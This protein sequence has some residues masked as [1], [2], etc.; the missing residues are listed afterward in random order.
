MNQDLLAQLVKITPEEQSILNGGAVNLG[1]YGAGKGFTVDSARLLAQGQL[2]TLRP[3]TRFAPFPR[4]SH[5]YVEMMYMCAGQTIHVINGEAPVT[6]NQGELLLLNQHASHAIQKAGASD[7]AVNFIVL[8]QFFDEALQMLGTENV[9]GHFLLGALQSSRSEIGYLHFKA[10][11]TL[12]VQA[13]VESM[14]WSL[15][16]G[17]NNARKI[18]QISMGL[19][20]LHLLNCTQTLSAEGAVHSVSPMVLAAL[21]E[22]EENCRG[23]VLKDV[24][25]K[26]DVSLSYLSSRIKADT[27]N[28]F[29]VLLQQKRLDKAT[30][31]LRDTMLSVQEIISAVGYENTSYFYRIFRA[32][33]GVSPK[34]YRG[35]VHGKTK[36]NP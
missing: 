3:H 19:L 15:L 13:L 8:P 1:S 24:A 25:Q 22:I 26:Y 16:H 32:Q 12:P 27:G 20:F 33:F 30:R 9:L 29:N 5:N 7:I 31:L 23:A 14:I 17:E 6:L 28:T 4:H 11:D 2:I 10:A 36:L 34:E 18:N 35:T 21:R